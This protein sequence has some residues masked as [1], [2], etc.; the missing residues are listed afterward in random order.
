MSIVVL[1]WTS[2]SLHLCCRQ[3]S[4][5]SWRISSGKAVSSSMSPRQIDVVEGGGNLRVSSTSDLLCL[6]YRRCH[7]ALIFKFTCLIILNLIII[8]NT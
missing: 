3:V 2:S 7:L 6:V 5:V 8:F 4:Q 1:N